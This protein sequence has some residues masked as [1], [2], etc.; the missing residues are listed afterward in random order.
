LAP[1]T[2]CNQ[3]RVLSTEVEDDDFFVHCSSSS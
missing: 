1:D 2:V 3:M